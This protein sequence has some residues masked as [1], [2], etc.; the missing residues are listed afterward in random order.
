MGIRRNI[1]GNSAA[2]D[3]YVQGVLLLKAEM[4]GTTTADLGIPSRPGVPVQNL[5]TWDLFVY[6]HMLAMFE[7]RAGRNAAHS[8][9]VFLPWH[10]W[11]MI[12][13]EAQFQRVL[14]DQD[15]GLPYWDWAADGE[16]SPA[17]QLSRPV[18]N[19][20][21]MGGDGRPSD[22]QVTTGP[23]SRT[24]PFR[25]RIEGT[26]IPGQIIATN[27][28]LRRSLGVGIS[29]L[30]QQTDVAAAIAGSVYDSPD[31]NRG[32]LG[33]RNFVEGWTPNPPNTHNRVHVWIGGDMGPASS[34]NDPTFF[35]NHCNVDR[36]WARWQS[37]NPS[38]AYVP[39]QSAASSL[40]RHRRSDPLHSIL[41]TN[42][43]L[44]SQMLNVSNFYTY[45]NLNVS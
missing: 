4:S 44:V 2:R 7:R 5:A 40:F 28:P 14:G 26:S 39:P 18:W 21:T 12:L 3:A 31:W 25:I 16:F 6:W 11:F 24:S 45:D 34:P 27:R 17:Q 20:S 32:S 8:G 1:V 42:Q 10:R 38:A 43:P 41:T 13:L 33:M 23:F 19:T 29:T 9:P 30:P 37:D 15:F 36:I 35:L 22:R